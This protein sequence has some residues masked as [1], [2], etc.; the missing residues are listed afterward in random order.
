MKRAHALMLGGL[1]AALLSFPVMAQP[2]PGGGM[3]GMGGGMGPGPSAAAVDCGKAR[4]PQQCEARQQ[5]MA[6]CQD[7]RGPA[8]RNCIE[9]KLPP[10]DCGQARNPQRCEAMNKARAA[11]KGKV[12]KERRVCMREQAPIRKSPPRAT[13]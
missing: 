7:Q 2:G 9:D 1:T 12:G 6:A 5:A 8:R 4:N 11:C 3:G 10:R 13:P